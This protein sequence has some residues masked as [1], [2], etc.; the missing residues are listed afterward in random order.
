MVEVA[1]PSIWHIRGSLGARGLNR[2]GKKVGGG[3]GG[4]LGGGAGGE[5]NVRPT[6]SGEYGDVGIVKDMVGN[7]RNEKW[8]SRVWVVVSEMGNGRRGVMGI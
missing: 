7:E 2:L 1:H 6:I 8:V 4:G 3:A 5:L